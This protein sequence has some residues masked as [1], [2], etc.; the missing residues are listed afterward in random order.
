MSKPFNKLN[1]KP[2]TLVVHNAKIFN[3]KDLVKNPLEHFI[4]LQTLQ[5]GIQI[6]DLE[7]WIV[8]SSPLDEDEDSW[9]NLR[10]Y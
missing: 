8:D 1:F 3:H 9:M 10:P 5:W 6:S 2:K 7:R 4:D